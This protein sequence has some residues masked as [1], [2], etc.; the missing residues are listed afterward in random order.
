[1]PSNLPIPPLDKSGGFLGG[2]CV[3]IPIT[4]LHEQL[5]IYEGED[6]IR[7]QE[8]EKALRNY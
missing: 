6:H 2:G 7:V 1:M 3:K 5:R 4:S 8:I